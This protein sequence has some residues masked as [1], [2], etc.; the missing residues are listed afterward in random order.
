MAQKGPE[1]NARLSVSVNLLSEF[2]DDVLRVSQGVVG[3]ELNDNDSLYI[4]TPIHK[5]K[6]TL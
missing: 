3:S 5:K 4:P 2:D 1:K 6:L